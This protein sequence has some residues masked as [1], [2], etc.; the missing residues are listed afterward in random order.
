[1]MRTRENYGAAMERGRVLGLTKGRAT[2]ASFDRDGLVAGGLQIL[3]G[4]TVSEGDVVFFCQF[5]DGSGLVLAMM[6]SSL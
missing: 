2:V 6:E 5:S 3:P 4:Q 1:M